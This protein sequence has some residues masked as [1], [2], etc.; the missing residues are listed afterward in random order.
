MSKKHTGYSKW[1]TYIVPEAWSRRSVKE[2]LQG[3]LQLSNRMI[4]RLTRSRGIRLNGKMPW[5]DRQV[6][7]GD[8]LKVAVRP[9]ERADLTAEPV[10]FDTVYEDKDLLVVNKPPGI[11]VH[12]VKPGE[13]GTLSHG[14]LYQWKQAGW[15]GKVRPVHRLDRYTS[16]LL[17]VAKYAYIHQL[18]DKELRQHRIKRTYITVTTGKWTDR[19]PAEG[20]IDAPIVRSPGHPL[21]RTVSDK[22]DPAITH[23]RVISESN[24]ATALEVRLET[25]RT[26]Q[27]RV[28]FAHMG[29]PLLGD[30]LYGGDLSAIS[31]QALHAR[32]LTFSHPLREET[33]TVEAPLPE[34]MEKLVRKHH[35]TIK[36]KRRSP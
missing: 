15:E 12:P 23:Y 25:G 3:P 5:L 32:R 21:R 1:I 29:F 8:Q 36:E 4:N 26:H 11:K 10:P 20:T 24:T 13:T 19:H 18:L 31:R 27:I 7:A 30:R 17:L 6:K 35:L 33:L 28:H 22:G 2:V 14:I 9:R 34:D 16:G